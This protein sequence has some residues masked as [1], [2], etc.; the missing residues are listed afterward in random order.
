MGIKDL[1]TSLKSI[2]QRKHLKEYEGQTLAIDGYAWLH[3]GAY[4]CAEDLCLGKPT[5]Q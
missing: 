3:K 5:K 1:L 4:S 2:E